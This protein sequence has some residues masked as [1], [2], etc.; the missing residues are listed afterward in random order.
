MKQPQESNLKRKL[1]NRHIQFI[2][3]GGAVGTG[4]FLGTGSTISVAGPAVILGY[5]IAGL[6]IF[7]IMRQLGEMETEEPMTGSFSYFAYKYWG[8][9]PGFLSGWNYWIQY[10]LVGIAELTA[11]AA[12]VQYWFPTLATWKTALFFFMLINAINLTAVKAY[13]EIEFW[14]SII[15]VTAICAMILVGGYILIVNTSLVDGAT[16]RNLWMAASVGENTGNPVL[17]GFFA[18]GIVGLLAAIPMITFAFGGLELI[19]ITAAETADPQKTIPKAINQVVFRVLILYISSITVLLSLYHWSNLQTIESPFVMIFDKIGFK[20]AAWVLNFVILSAALSVYNSCIYSN[21]RTL[22]GLALQNN[23]PQIFSKT[24]KKGIPAAAQML[25]GILTFLVVPLNYFLPNWVD[26]FQAIISFVVVCILINWGLITM[27]HMKF[28]KQ[29][30][31]ENHKT[32]FPSPFYPYTNYIVF[33]FIL[34]ILIIMAILQ[35]MIKQA[36]AVPIWILIVYVF[37]KVSTIKTTK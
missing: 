5:L 9:F 3:I 16:I 29:K 10:V 20:H 21:S 37:Y 8:K 28:K 36:I 26:A 4:L 35:G 1:T 19:G 22:Y 27:S 23:A 30:N 25:S 15:K 32:L 6:S 33:A 2:A 12:Y 31:L 17:S 14:F 34:L 11:V 18:H 13:A 7:L 24:T